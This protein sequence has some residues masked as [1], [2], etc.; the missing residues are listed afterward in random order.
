VTLRQAGVPA[1]LRTTTSLGGG[2]YRVSF[3][4]APGT[5]PAT[6]T[7]YGRDRDGRVNS[8]VVALTVP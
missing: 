7:L 1:V 6:L 2:R 4:I 8:Q 3:T 5:G